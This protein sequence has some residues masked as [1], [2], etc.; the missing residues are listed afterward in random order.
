[1]DLALKL[2]RQRAGASEGA[3]SRRG[4]SPTGHDK[5]GA[6][7][8]GPDEGEATKEKASRSKSPPPMPTCPRPIREKREETQER[9]GDDERRKRVE[10]QEEWGSE[11]F[12]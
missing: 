8:T 4:N 11:I 3:V 10:L 1:M 5:G 12:L 2:N 9:R 7:K 6:K